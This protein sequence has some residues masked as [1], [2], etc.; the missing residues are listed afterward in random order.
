MQRLSAAVL[1][2]AYTLIPEGLHVVGQ[3]MNPQQLMQTLATCAKAWYELVLPAPVLQ[4]LAEGGSA[5]QALELIEASPAGGDRATLD[6]LGKLVS[7][8]D[9]LLQDNEIAGIVH[10]LDGGFLR[11]APGGDL[12]RTPDVLPTGRNVHGFDPF[13][14]P[15]AY[16]VK[17]GAR[18]AQRLLERYQADG[19]GL[20]ESIAMVLWGTDN[21]KSEG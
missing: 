21:L 9:E 10:A 14:I 11:P 8:R 17:D 2:L 20:P 18:Q 16:A 6:Q 12:L 15:S 13:R 19:H 3:P 1:E 5:R 4:L 7:A